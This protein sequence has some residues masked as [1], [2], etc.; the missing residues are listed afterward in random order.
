M[1]KRHAK[2]RS[3]GAQVTFKCQEKGCDNEFLDA[4]VYFHAIRKHFYICP[5][6]RPKVHQRYVESQE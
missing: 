4:P 6:C 2:A 5:T 1:G 3:E